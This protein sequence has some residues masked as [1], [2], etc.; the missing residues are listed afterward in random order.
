MGFSFFA[1]PLSFL[2]LTCKF[3]CHVD[4]ASHFY[5]RNRTTLMKPEISTTIMK[6]A[7]GLL[8]HWL[9][10]CVTTLLSLPRAA[11]LVCYSGYSSPLFA[12]TVEA[13]ECV[14]YCFKC[15]A[16]DGACT[17]QE[18]KDG[19]VKAVYTAVNEDTKKYLLG[20]SMRLNCMPLDGC[21]AR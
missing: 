12:G 20:V 15:S 2:G 6:S 17:L 9:V 16:D 5:E 21:T 19:T 18:Q 10:I 13:D 7:R 14:K 11:S 3:A 4:T 8:V 1:L